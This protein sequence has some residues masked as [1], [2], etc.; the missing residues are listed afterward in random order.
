M[1]RFPLRRHVTH[2]AVIACALNLTACVPAEEVRVLDKDFNAA[3]RADLQPLD[4]VQQ[5]AGRAMHGTYRLAASDVLSPAYPVSAGRPDEVH[6]SNMIQSDCVWLAHDSVR[7]RGD[8]LRLNWEEVVQTEPPPVGSEPGYMGE[9][10]GMCTGT[11]PVSRTLPIDT[12]GS[13]AN[14]STGLEAGTRTLYVTSGSAGLRVTDSVGAGERLVLGCSTS[15]T[16]VEG[17]RRDCGAQLRMVKDVQLLAAFNSSPGS[18]PD[19]VC[20]RPALSGIG[21]VVASGD[22]GINLP[23]RDNRYLPSCALDASLMPNRDGYFA[24]RPAANWMPGRID[25][26]MGKTLI[27][28]GVMVVDG[29]RTITRPMRVSGPAGGFDTRWS[30]P[31]QRNANGEPRWEENFSP[32]IAVGAAILRA[33]D[34]FTGAAV[35]AFQGQRLCLE[36]AAGACSTLC[37]PYSSD[38]STLVFLL[39]S[40]HCV[41]GANRPTQPDVSP[42]YNNQLLSDSPSSPQLNPL[43]WRLETPARANF[44]NPWVRITFS[45]RTQLP[46]GFAL[47]AEHG[48]M[49]LG[50]TQVSGGLVHQMNQ[51]LNIGEIPMR[52]E[53]A[54]IIGDGSASSRPEAF[55]VLLAGAPVDVPAPVDF[56]AVGDGVLAELGLGYD[57]QPVYSVRGTKKLAGLARNPL[58]QSEF[59]LY[60]RPFRVINGLITTNSPNFDFFSAGKRDF[61]RRHPEQAETAASGRML[62]FD[63]YPLLSLPTALASGRSLNMH[64]SFAPRDYG[65]ATA[66]LRVTASASS[67]APQSR[68]IHVLLRGH[69]VMGALMEAM[70]ASI[71]LP[72]VSGGNVLLQS[73]LAVVNIGQLPGAIRSIRIDG[74]DRSRFGILG[75]PALPLNMQAGD[76][77]SLVIEAYPRTCRDPVVGAQAQLIIEGQ[78]QIPRQIDLRLAK[79]VCR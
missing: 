26:S 47:R 50:A 72:R 77:L 62:G 6:A 5:S 28:P 20:M 19:G 65:P 56:V 49:D 71:A 33:V 32:S 22:Q 31:V 8:K 30:V 7:A 76:A 9:H 45:L 36:N 42:S 17:V 11:D 23:M 44:I 70:P 4:Q 43:V 37:R 2:V 24:L 79:E 51:M 25:S 1:S 12:D 67:G 14:A 41:D 35:P 54:E 29:G 53:R 68:T 48:A 61:L 18:N 34:P 38:P 13:S 58:T 59:Q 69:G 3:F 73:G 78:G 16:T 60:E 10:T 15:S 66:L 39:D 55:A 63:A 75:M 46:Q 40:T 52:V 57:R 64:V 21:P 74:K 27:G